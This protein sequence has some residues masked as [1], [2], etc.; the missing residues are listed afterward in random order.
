MNQR[1]S[2]VHGSKGTDEPWSSRI[3][4]AFPPRLIDIYG[5]QAQ[6]L[7]VPSPQRNFP[8]S[9]LAIRAQLQGTFVSDADVNAI[10]RARDSIGQI[11]KELTL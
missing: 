1:L 11:T 8:D 5:V 2:T 9:G 7:Y 10:H 6:M 4:P 3:F